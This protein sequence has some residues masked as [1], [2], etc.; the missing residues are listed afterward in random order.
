MRLALIAALLS[1]PALGQQV[2]SSPRPEAV[3]VT[4]YRDPGRD[5][6]GMNLRWL[7]GFALITETRTMTLPAGRSTIRFESVAGGIVP[8]SAIVQG[9]PGGVIEK[10]R[11]RALLSP[12]ALVNGSLGR[13]VLLRR[14]DPGSGKVREDDAVIRSGSAGAV[15]VETKAG[16]EALRCSGLPETIVYDQVPQGLSATPTLSVETDSPAPA[17]VIATRWC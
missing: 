17:T 11:D 14:T 7:G 4:V 16:V 6:G 9:L 1:T 3:A 10:N 8:V 13:H 5:S 15:V 2:V 12:A